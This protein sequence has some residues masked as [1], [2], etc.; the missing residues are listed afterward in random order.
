[1]LKN[2][3]ATM[4]IET[5]VGTHCCDSVTRVNSCEPKITLV[6]IGAAVTLNTIVPFDTIVAGIIPFE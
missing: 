6:S 4:V 1:L 2:I 3:I 5:M